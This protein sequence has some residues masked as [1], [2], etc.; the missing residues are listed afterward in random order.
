MPCKIRTKNFIKGKDFKGIQKIGIIKDKYSIG[1]ILG[2]GNYG[3]VR[4]SLHKQMLVP[5]AIKIIKKELINT[6][7]INYDLMQNELN[8][9]EELSHPN[10]IR[11]YELLENNKSYYIV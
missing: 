4:S 2:K 1:S 7:I 5:C 11:I 9:L 8:V 10:M 6:S 3:V